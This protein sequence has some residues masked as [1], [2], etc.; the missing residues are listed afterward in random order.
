MFFIG[1]ASARKR[2]AGGR[3]HCASAAVSPSTVSVDVN[4]RL[5]HV[6]SV[7]TLLCDTIVLVYIQAA[8]CTLCC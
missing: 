8:D 3:L 4:F 5:T 7:G 1:I 2:S 6:F